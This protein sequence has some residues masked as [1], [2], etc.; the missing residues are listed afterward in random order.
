MLFEL[1]DSSLIPNI[2][3]TPNDQNDTLGSKNEKHSLILLL[4]LLLLLLF[5]KRNFHSIIIVKSHD[6]RLPM[7]VEEYPPTKTNPHLN[8]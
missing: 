1:L 8:F 2:M 4:L 5:F 6:T 7:Q 3:R